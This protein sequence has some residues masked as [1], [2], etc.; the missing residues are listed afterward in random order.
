MTMQNENSPPHPPLSATKDDPKIQ[1]LTSGTLSITLQVERVFADMIK[2]LDIGNS[3][4][5]F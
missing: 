4:W 1:A 2:H 3:S 5:I